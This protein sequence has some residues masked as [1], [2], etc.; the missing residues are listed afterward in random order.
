MEEDAYDLS[1]IEEIEQRLLVTTKFAARLAAE[2]VAKQVLDR[3][4][5]GKIIQGLKPRK[6][7]AEKAEKRTE[8]IAR[9]EVDGQ[10]AALIQM[11][12]DSQFSHP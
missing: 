5:V 7:R 10:Q 2:L 3:R 1:E 11:Q 8:K 12:F 9:S 4:D 6:E